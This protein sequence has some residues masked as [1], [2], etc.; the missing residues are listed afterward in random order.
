MK[1]SE[2]NNWLTLG[3]NIGVLAGIIFLALELQQNSAMLE[4]QARSIRQ[5]IRLADYTLPLYNE[6]FA[7]ALL[8]YGRNEELTEYE[9]LLVRRGMD[10]TLTNFQYVYNEYLNGLI[11]ESELPVH[12]WSNAFTGGERSNRD[13][14]PDLSEYWEEM[15]Y[16]NYDPGFVEWM[17]ANVAN[18]T[19]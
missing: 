16:I 11:E 14:W 6:N 5:E 12:V 7:N 8:K 4:S 19:N 17:D 13:Y 1:F 3:A 10:I 9:N 18:G 15:K 2:L